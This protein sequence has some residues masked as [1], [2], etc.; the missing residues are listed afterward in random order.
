M[1]D[2]ITTT[3]AVS[4]LGYGP[5]PVFGEVP[6]EAFLSA[7]SPELAIFSILEKQGRLENFQVRLEV[8]GYDLEIPEQAF[9]ARKSG[10]GYILSN[11]PEAPWPKLVIEFAPASS[12]TQL[13]VARMFVRPID[14]SVDAEILYTRALFTLDKAQQL[15]LY[16]EKIGEIALG[17]A[18][19]SEQALTDLLIRAKI[20]R[21]VKYIEWVFRT[22]FSLTQQYT[23]EHMRDIDLVFRGLTEAEF[24][25]RAPSTVL[26]IAPSTVDLNKPPFT[27]IGEFSSYVVDAQVNILG[28]P[29]NVGPIYFR[30]L[31]A[32]IA[33]PGDLA[34]LS[35]NSDEPV[36]IQFDL[37]DNQFTCRFENY[38]QKSLKKLKERFDRFI[39]ELFRKEPK[40][41][42]KLIT[43]PLISQV[44]ADEAN[45]ISFGWLISNQM[46]DR[47]CPQEPELDSAAG[48]WRVPI[49][50]V[51]SNGEGGQVGEL[52]IDLWTGGVIANPSAED[53]SEQATA[54]AQTILNAK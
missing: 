29:I 2:C 51:Y 42:I 13:S 52:K 14:F 45:H 53:M 6:I 28:K 21:K 24:I 47:F 23:V 9:E 44:S 3:E 8:P 22:N 20:A 37:I 30:H 33:K 12:Q 4:S 34:Q 46:P 17:V 31:K 10:G 49:F 26:Q 54:L 1:N 25:S 32:K 11:K 41:L 7:E 5:V 35:K 39:W 19:L 40:E 50:I 15:T 16:I 36:P 27:G 38:A 48:C 43:E 18:P